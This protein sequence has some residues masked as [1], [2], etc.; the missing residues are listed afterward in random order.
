MRLLTSRLPSSIL[1]AIV[2]NVSSSMPRSRIFLLLGLL[3]Y[4]IFGYG[5]FGMIAFNALKHSVALSKSLTNPCLLTHVAN[6]LQISGCMNERYRVAKYISKFS[7]VGTISVSVFDTI[8]LNNSKN[9]GKFVMPILYHSSKKGSPLLA[10][11]PQ[12]LF[13]PS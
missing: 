7:S 9:S 5:I 10:G 12:Q 11:F 3:I 13:F 6:I 1:Y 8:D 4:L 2:F